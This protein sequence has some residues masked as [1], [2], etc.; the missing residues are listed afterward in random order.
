[1]LATLLE[2]DVPL[3]QTLLPNLTLGNWL[4]HARKAP[5]VPANDADWYSRNWWLDALS[6]GVAREVDPPSS[7]AAREQLHNAATAGFDRLSRGHRIFG[8]WAGQGARAAVQSRDTVELTRQQQLGPYS[9]EGWGLPLAHSVLRAVVTLNQVQDVPDK[10]LNEASRQ[11]LGQL[12][13]RQL[14]ERQL[15][16]SSENPLPTA[17]PVDQLGYCGRLLEALAWARLAID[18]A[19]DEGPAQIGPALRDCASSVAAAM[20]PLGLTAPPAGPPTGDAQAAQVRRTAE[21]VSQALRGLR[22]VRRAYW[23]APAANSAPPH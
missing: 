11:L 12:V 23:P 6:I 19:I 16:A 21:G 14:F 17:K 8:T 18:S 10:T 3:E 1:V 4:E 2:A 15:W 20:K 22:M 7:A 5:A 9:L 13:V